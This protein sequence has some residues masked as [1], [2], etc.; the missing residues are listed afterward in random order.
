MWG[1]DTSSWVKNKGPIEAKSPCLGG[2]PEH[3]KENRM[4]VRHSRR[5]LEHIPISPN[6]LVSFPTLDAEISGLTRLGAPNH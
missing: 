4:G 6:A 2:D 1:V 5:G 3:S